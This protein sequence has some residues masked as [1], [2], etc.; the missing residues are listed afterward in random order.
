MTSRWLVVADVRELDVEV[1]SEIACARCRPVVLLLDVS[2]R[3][4]AFCSPSSSAC[5]WR[6]V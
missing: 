1:E 2:F 6:A 4:I 3:G 5:C